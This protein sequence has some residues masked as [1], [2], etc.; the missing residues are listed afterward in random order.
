MVS[1][2]VG[3]RVRAVQRLSELQRPLWRPREIFF[4]LCFSILLSGNKILSLL[5][6]VMFCEL[7]DRISQGISSSYMNLL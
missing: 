1:V 3:V 7:V 5:L 2:V 6:V 4:L